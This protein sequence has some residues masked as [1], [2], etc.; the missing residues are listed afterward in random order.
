MAEATEIA[1][2]PM[3]IRRLLVPAARFAYQFLGIFRPPQP[4]G[5]H[6]TEPSWGWIPAVSLAS[7][8]GLTVMAVGLGADKHSRPSG[9]LLLNA[10][11]LML[12]VPLTVRLVWPSVSRFE[13][14]G[15]VIVAGVSIY[16]VKVLPRTIGFI[17]FDEFLHWVTAADIMER[18]TL[19]TE[20]PLLPISP[21]YP[22]LEIL[23]TSIANVTGLSIFLSATLLLAV[24]RVLFVSALFQ[25]FETITASSRVAALGCLVYMGNSAFLIFHAAFAYES[26]A[27]VFLALVFLAAAHAEHDSACGWTYFTFLAIPFLVALAMTHHTAAFI[28]VLLLIN[29]VAL[30]FVNQLTPQYRMGMVALVSAA[31]M[32]SIGWLILMGNP[33]LDYLGPPVQEGMTTLYHMVATQKE[34][35]RPFVGNDGSAS[36]AWQQRTM[37]FSL[38]LVCLGL[39]MGFFRTL[40]LAGLRIGR[41]SG[42]MP[43]GITWTNNWLVLLTAIT[44]AFPVTVALRL[45]DG[46]WEIGN[47]LGPFL[48]FGISPVVAVA[49]ADGWQGGSR[50]LFRTATSSASLTIMLLG[51]LFAAWGG[52]IELPRRYKVIGDALSIEPMGIAAAQWMKEWLGPANRIAADRINRLLMATYGRQR[53]ITT[54]QDQIDISST[55]FAEQLGPKELN[56]L[57]VGDIDYVVVDMRMTTA[58][59]RMGVYFERGEEQVIHASPPDPAALLKFS[60]TPHVSRLFDNGYIMI[61]DV[62]D[63]VTVLHNER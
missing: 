54:L 3:M 6:P 37:L 14:I 18:K 63:L 33:V 32:S 19:F 60:R 26:L 57:K 45:T 55:F 7:A 23:A 27:I 10:G 20:N 58:M 25:F 61:Y 21:L 5:S 52:P 34:V 31:A 35:R 46:G 44:M 42:R 38:L 30:V 39:A 36:P 13:R 24:L 16:I 4:Q 47:R 28:G 48:Y 11:F 2:P 15:L 49:V 62:A 8:L 51:G 56:T 59:P 12:L 9:V 43:L 40:L 17:D 29:L 41:R 22:A 1:R 53:I 50:N